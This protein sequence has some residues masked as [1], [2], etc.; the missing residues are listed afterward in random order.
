VSYGWD[1]ASARFSLRFL[2]LGFLAVNGKD[3]VGGQK[4]TDLIWHID[5]FPCFSTPVTSFLFLGWLRLL[6][7]AGHQHHGNDPF[8]YPMFSLL[9]TRWLE[10][11][12]F[13]Y[14]SG[15]EGCWT[16]SRFNED[17]PL[18]FRQDVHYKTRGGLEAQ[19]LA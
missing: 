14:H 1:E 16:G 17:T 15:H 5:S 6:A 7:G 19:S 3:L 9:Y 13:L 8:S 11:R 10:R 12:S 18:V 2:G 4:R